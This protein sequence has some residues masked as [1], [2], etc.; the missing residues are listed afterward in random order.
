MKRFFTLVASLALAACSSSSGEPLKLGAPAPDVNALDSSGKT[1]DLAARLKDGLALV[2]FYPKADTPGCTAQA[3]SLRDSYEDL[4]EAGV[5]IYGVSMDPVDAQRAF[6]DKHNLPFTLLADPDGKVVK[7]FG[8]PA[9]GSFASRQ[10]FL[11]QDGKLV[12]RD[13]NAST[14]KQAEDV[15][16]VLASLPGKQSDA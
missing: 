4:Q 7:S 2:Y 15:R 1:V 6:K 10:A 12:W 14:R 16:K 3:C 8:V 5:T 13:L 9:R 11:F